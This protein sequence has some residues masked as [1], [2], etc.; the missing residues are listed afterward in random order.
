MMLELFR[1][2]IGLSKVMRFILYQTAD[3][4]RMRCNTVRPIG[5]SGGLRY[6]M[7]SSVKSRKTKNKKK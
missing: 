6:S 2:D 4:R 7:C 1:T 3:T 5:K